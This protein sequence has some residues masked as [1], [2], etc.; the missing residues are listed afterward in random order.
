[1]VSQKHLFDL[2]ENLHYLNC[3]YMSPQLKSATQIGI[4]S[5]QRKSNPSQFTPA[6]FFSEVEVAR[7]LF[8]QL[9]NA[10]A[11]QT[12]VIPS[13]S[14]GMANVFKNI[15]FT[16][17][18]HAITISKEFPSGYFTAKGWC[19]THGAE[20]K[21]IEPNPNATQKAKDWNERI[22]DSIS[23]QSAVIVLSS[24]HWMDGMKLD[25]EAIGNRCQETGTALI[26]DGTQS[27]GALPMD[28]QKYK[29]D[30]LIC[31]GYKW[32]MTPY[33]M[34]FAYYGER[35]NDGIPIEESWMNRSNAVQFSSLTD[36]DPTYKSGAGRYMVGQATHPVQMPMAIESLRHLLKWKPENIQKYCKKLTAPLIDFLGEIGGSVIEEAYRSS[37]ILGMRLPENINP[38][39]LVALLKAK[40]IILSLRGSSIRISPNVYNTEADVLALMGAMAE[41]LV[42]Q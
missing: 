11:Q 32:M 39:D 22:L 26:V 20:L 41:V 38:A 3:A 21:V 40:N 6:D 16:A 5:V 37:H 31:G 30:A 17:G 18:Q 13:V 28:V 7:S 9:V 19:E 4:E 25:L 27:V 42:D 36:Y 15:P 34:G 33:S 29:I 10:D 12:V 1:M 23:S 8:G 35:F 14:Y 2:P 24:V